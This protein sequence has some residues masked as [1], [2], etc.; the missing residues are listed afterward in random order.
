[1]AGTNWTKT[2]IGAMSMAAALVA[3]SPAFPAVFD[4]TALANQK[5]ANWKDYNIASPSAG[6]TFTDASDTWTIGTF[7]VQASASNNGDVVS[8][9]AYLDSGNAGLGVCSTP[10]GCTGSSDDNTGLAG[11]IGPAL[12]TLI[13]TFSTTVKLDSLTFRKRNHGMYGA[14]DL[15]ISLNGTDFVSGGDLSG[16]VG[17]VFE[18]AR[19]DDSDGGNDFYL[20]TAIVSAV[21]V[22][23]TAWFMLTTVGGLVGMRWLRRG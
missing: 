8:S 10:T 15:K 12:E 22:P 2:G 1:M 20:D 16:A 3:W 9:F 17:T 13:L 6:G 14:G 5:E 11:D 7:G 23:A 18:L 19:L 4:F 21:P